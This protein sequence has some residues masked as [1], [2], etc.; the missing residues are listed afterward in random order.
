VRHPHGV[1]EAACTARHKR[2]VAASVD[3][4]HGLGV[5]FVE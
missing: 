3:L 1:S 2:L 5:V 4:F